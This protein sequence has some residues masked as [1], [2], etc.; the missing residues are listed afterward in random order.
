MLPQD[1]LVQDQGEVLQRLAVRSRLKMKLRHAK[2][3][4]AL[5]HSIHQAMHNTIHAK[6]VGPAG[7]GFASERTMLP[8]ETRNRPSLLNKCVAI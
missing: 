1:G 3:S 6:V 8:V 7:L 5:R 4:K 2:D